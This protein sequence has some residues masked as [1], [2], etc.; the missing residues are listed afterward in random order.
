MPRGEESELDASA[1]NNGRCTGDLK[2]KRRENEQCLGQ[3][4]AT[5]GFTMVLLTLRG[6]RCLQSCCL[7]TLSGQLLLWIICAVNA[8]EQSFNVEDEML[9]GILQFDAPVRPECCSL[10]EPA[11]QTLAAANLTAP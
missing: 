2:K 8:E 9:W 11:Q 5:A 6:R 1:W 10:P 4:G 3:R 7:W